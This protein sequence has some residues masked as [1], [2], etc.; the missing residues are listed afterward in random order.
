MNYK[1][2]AAAA[3]GVDVRA[4]AVLYVQ[5]TSFIKYITALP[6]KEMT[7]SSTDFAVFVTLLWRTC[8]SQLPATSGTQNIG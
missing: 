4:G 5:S 7:S 8:C 1:R 2:D 6:E 3:G